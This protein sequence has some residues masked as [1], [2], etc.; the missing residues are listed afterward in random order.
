MTISPVQ[1]NLASSQVDPQNSPQ[2]PGPEQ[3][4]K[5]RQIA[6]AIHAINEH[7]VFGPG[8]ELRFSIDPDTG[9]GLIRIVDRT[10]NEVLNQIPSEEL[11]RMWA[12]LQEL[13][14]HHH[15]A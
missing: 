5:N 6:R 13:S 3:A 15:L 8:S 14:D 4:A 7:Q 1:I 12:L 2:G 10:T 9:R 11:L